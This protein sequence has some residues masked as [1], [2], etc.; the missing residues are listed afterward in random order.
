MTAPSRS[1]T[2]ATGTGN[3]G[4]GNGGAGAAETIARLA[5]STA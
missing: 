3:R 1:G 4:T 2:R 5:A